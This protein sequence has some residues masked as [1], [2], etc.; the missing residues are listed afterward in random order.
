MPPPEAL[1]LALLESSLDALAL[2]SVA[3]LAVPTGVAVGMEALGSP[4]PSFS[5]S[6]FRFR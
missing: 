3:A 6:L 2:T 4:S 1:K 5:L